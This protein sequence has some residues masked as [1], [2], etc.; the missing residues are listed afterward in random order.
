M[1]VEAR[2]A[3]HASD[4]R[5]L[6][7]RVVADVIEIGRLL[8]EAK[9]IAGHGNWLPWLER[10]FHWTEQTAVNFMRVHEM[11]SKSKKFLDLDLPLSGLYLL[12]APSTP[13]QVR[14]EI[15]KAGEPLSVKE[16]KAKIAEATSPIWWLRCTA[17]GAGAV[18]GACQP[19]APE[20]FCIDCEEGAGLRAGCKCGEPYE[21]VLVS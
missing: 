16:I 14:S 9:A 3:K 8:T 21:R 6:G 20:L 13:K 15:I 19:N 2:L 17:C 10:E 5:R 11:V 18:C 12:A 7:K 1:K 4:I